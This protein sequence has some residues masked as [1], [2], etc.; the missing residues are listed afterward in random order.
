L[1]ECTLSKRTLSEC[2]LS[3]RTLSEPTLFEQ[4]YNPSRTLFGDKN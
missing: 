3:E 4:A 1:F 2:T